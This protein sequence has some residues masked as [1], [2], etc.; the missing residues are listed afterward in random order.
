MFGDFLRASSRWLGKAQPCARARKKN[1]YLY[2]ALGIEKAAEIV[3]QI[4][5]A[6][7]SSSDETIFGNC[8]FE[9]LSRLAAEGKVADGE[10]V[11]FVVESRK[12]ILAVAVKSGPNWGNA[13]Q[14]KR[15][16]TN[17]D[18]LRRRLQKIQK[19]FDPL[20][21]QCYGRQWSEPTEN[22]RYRRRSG[23][24]FWVEI[25]G[26]AD[27]YLK[28]VRLMRDVPER[29]REKY[30]LLWSQGVNRFS[31]QFM[32]KFCSHSGA[33]DWEKLVAFSSG[34]KRPE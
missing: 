23:Q 29:N 2:R 27:F 9:P 8:F 20:C 19:Q 12:R 5:A 11:D 15:Q 30:R 14:H 17:F 25:T 3:E 4:M 16:S 24:A 32:E 34:E 28:L 33:I 26:D 6:H 13:D 18:A 22:A 10:G 31:Q 21:G 7:V 1:P